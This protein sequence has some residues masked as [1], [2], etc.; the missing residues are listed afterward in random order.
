MKTKKHTA[1]IVVEIFLL[2][3]SIFAFSY[4]VNEGF[5]S[6]VLPPQ[7]KQT[8][9][10]EKL[11]RL[12]ID[13][14]NLVSAQ[15]PGDIEVE[16]P[17]PEQE[18]QPEQPTQQEPPPQTSSPQVGRLQLLAIA[19]A[20]NSGADIETLAD[21]FGVDVLTAVA[22]DVAGLEG[23]PDSARDLNAAQI[24]QSLQSE[25]VSICPRTKDNKIC[26]DYPSS[27]CGEICGEPCVEITSF[28]LG[29]DY[30]PSLIP[31]E[32]RLGVCVDEEVGTCQPLS[33]FG[34]CETDGGKWYSPENTPTQ[35]NVGCCLIADQAFFETSQQCTVRAEGY[36]LEI[37]GD[38]ANF[39]PNILDEPTCLASAQAYTE[40]QGACVYE[41]DF[42]TTCKFT[43]ENDCTDSIQGQFNAGK[44]CSHPDL[45]T[46]CEK[47]I[48]TSCDLE[49]DAVYWYDSCDNREN[50]FDSSLEDNGWNDGEV[51]PRAESCE[52]GS[53]S[54]P[55]TNQ[56]TCGNCNR[57]KG[58]TCK[59][60]AEGGGLNNGNFICR[61]LSCG[62]VEGDERENGESWCGYQSSIG[63]DAIVDIPF[64]GL[65]NSFFGGE[66]KLGPLTNII[67]GKRST[68]TPGSRHFR[69]TCIDGEVVIE[70]C[71]N[72][73]NEI[74]I[75]STTDEKGRDFST[76]SCT[77][78]RWQECLNYNQRG[79]GGNAKLQAAKIAKS[80][81]SC[82]KDPDCFVKLV[83]VDD[84]FAFPMCAPKYPP[85]FDKDNPE[86]AETICS[87]ATQTCNVIKVK[88]LGGEDVYNGE[89]ETP[90]F[91]EQMND[92]C[93]SL[94][95][96]GLS[97]N[98]MGDFGAPGTG[99]V[100][101]GKAQGFGLPIPNYDLASILYKNGLRRFADWNGKPIEATE[102]RLDFVGA[103]S[104]EAF[105]FGGEDGGSSGAEGGDGGGS[106]RPIGRFNPKPGDGY[107]DSAIVPGLI[108]GASGVAIAQIGGNF[109]AIGGAYTFGNVL[110]GAA[111]GMAIS[112]FLIDV[113][114]VGRGL[115]PVATYTLIGAG[116][117]GGALAG[118]SIVV[119]ILA[120]AP[121]F[122]GNPIGFIILAVVIIIIVL[123]KLFGVGDVEKSYY[124][125]ECRPWEAPLGG[126]N[127]EKCGTDADSD[128]KYP[129][130]KYSCESLGQACV[131]IGEEPDGQCVAASPSDVSSADINII[132]QEG[133]EISCTQNGCTIRKA[134]GACFSQFESVRIVAR[135]DEYIGSCKL[136]TSPTTP[137]E[138][139]TI[140]LS[141]STTSEESKNEFII[142]LDPQT[143]TDLAGGFI[144]GRA[145]ITLYLKCQDVNGNE[146]EAATAINICI[147]P[148]DFTAPIL[149]KVSP[150]LDFVSSDATE[151][152][153]V[154][155][156]NKPSQLRWDLS[157]K[158][159]D[160]M[161]NEFECISD[162][163]GMRCTAT[164]PIQSDENSFCVKGRAEGDDN[165]EEKTNKQC[166]TIDLKKTQ[167]LE[168]ISLSPDGDTYSFGVISP[169]VE[170]VAETSG[171]LEGT[172]GCT[173]E[174][175]GVNEV[176]FFQVEG[177]IHTQILGAGTAILAEGTH[178]LKVKCTDLV[179]NEAER[180]TT[181]TLEKDV[182]PPQVT[183]VYNDGGNL[184]IITSEPAKCAYVNAPVQGK[185]ACGFSFDDEINLFTTSG[186]FH[187]TSF[188]SAKKYYIK[189]KDL[190]ENQLRTDQCNIVVSRGV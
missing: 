66:S 56:N 12:I 173:Y 129:C 124:T 180:E 151:Q 28:Q 95:D 67:G 19:Q 61:D 55:T 153:V 108:T 24:F 130:N 134:G 43:T 140:P 131:F 76:A 184:V 45:E 81:L 25:G 74:C 164:L 100:R 165:I 146:N 117:V 59:E 172:I 125:F 18:P 176:P 75:E 127:C 46:N 8:S 49:L 40:Q 30:N 158:D 145:D 1:K 98:Y 17:P 112:A 106:G 156:A 94:G 155:F 20:I 110:V 35:C 157:D 161:S 44:L 149:T 6:Q 167:P 53:G 178:D 36:G 29:D 96:C 70:P 79:G 187:S 162:S 39:D 91:F 135:G 148:D 107:A 84:D 171:G 31:S 132:E 86:A 103:S 147:I 37:G 121:I 77:I 133:Q 163:V 72:Y 190:F 58:N 41:E 88:T 14:K 118:Y 42:E 185:T 186:D 80:M 27:Q 122:G 139:M 111:A 87:A 142:P 188:N 51:L 78:N 174:Y 83:K 101:E 68:D 104:G 73:R 5:A 138:E 159:Y 32:C 38:T 137:F 169:E 7:S 60:V 69:K 141:E 170:I 34:K 109:L 116:T 54:S 120:D 89:C 26:Q 23:L 160:S 2:I 9:L 90:K 144:E 71:Q 154:V 3:S 150:L 189:C 50:I 15:A 10:I 62:N 177:N 143:L 16:V 128:G 182:F 65:A 92:L 52:V 181:F 47:T 97:V 168:I 136:D 123:L 119:Q 48:Y 13:D 105:G 4:L 21:M 11:I 82:E 114:G 102:D 175:E 22:R 113:L 166:L 126:A 152:E 33:T 57:F 115:G 179:G 183:R 93:I 85:G 99:F 63:T 64:L